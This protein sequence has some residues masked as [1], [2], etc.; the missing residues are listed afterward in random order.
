LSVFD[1]EGTYRPTF[2]ESEKKSF[3]L[4]HVIVAIGQVPDLSMFKEA[5]EIETT[6]KGTIKVDD[7]LSTPLKGVFA[8]G[9]AVT[10]TS[11]VIES[12]VMGKKAA[13]PIDRYLGGE[14]VVREEL[15]RVEEVSPRLG[16]WPGFA[17]L[18]RAKMSCTPIEERR[19]FVEVEKG[20]S[21]PMA[22]EEANRCLQCQLRF[23][24]RSPGFSFPEDR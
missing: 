24:V 15:A 21:E 18:V 16:R 3:V 20:L 7:N 2:D 11:S 19:S 9:D 8:T 4:N 12:I 1:R 10:G 17:G 6:Q 23:Q 14:G 13:G 22:A 5:G